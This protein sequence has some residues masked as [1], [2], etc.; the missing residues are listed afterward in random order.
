MEKKN[1]IW[2]LEKKWSL[3]LTTTDSPFN[4]SLQ[5]WNTNF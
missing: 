4:E 5:L 2:G 1:K 3:E